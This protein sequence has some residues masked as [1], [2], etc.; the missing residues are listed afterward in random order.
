[1]NDS[2][3]LIHTLSP[4]HI[5]VKAEAGDWREAVQLV[6]DLLV[7]VGIAGPDYTKA[8]IQAIEDLG[9]YCVIAP[10]VALPHARPDDGVHQIGFVVVTLQDPV[11]FGNDENDPVDLLIG[12]AAVDKTK[13]I[14]ALR[15]ISS[16]ISNDHLI[17]SIRKATTS[18]E[19][20]SIINPEGNEL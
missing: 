12:L 16:L 19:L 1:M 5:R 4:D 7:E 9:P 3:D 11:E 15:E 18:Q 10:G 14:Q 17:K 20:Y 2:I 6:G 8:M 13:H